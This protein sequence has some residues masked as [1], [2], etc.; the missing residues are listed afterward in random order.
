LL[1][2][3]AGVKDLLRLVQQAFHLSLKLLGVSQS[4]AGLMTS[5]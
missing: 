5:C 2:H 3:V 4:Q 1:P